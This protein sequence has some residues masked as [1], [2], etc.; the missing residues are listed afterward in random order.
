M[1]TNAHGASTSSRNARIVVET[2]STTLT[3]SG[4]LSAVVSAGPAAW[5]N[6]AAKRCRFSSARSPSAGAPASGDMDPGRV[7][8]LVVTGGFSLW[9][10]GVHPQ[11]ALAIQRSRTA[12]EARNA[13]DFDRCGRVG[14]LAQRED[15]A[16][17]E[18]EE[19]A[20][21]DGH[22]G[23]HAAHREP[24]AQQVVLEALAFFGR[25]LALHGG[26]VP[27]RVELQI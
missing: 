12:G 17:L 20:D 22:L 24:H 11:C 26:E 6:P 4:W 10:H 14:P 8:V 25:E 19:V 7:G 18:L 15:R 5:K 3:A 16:R 21:G 2:T 13:F 27:V 1:S 9:H 23:E